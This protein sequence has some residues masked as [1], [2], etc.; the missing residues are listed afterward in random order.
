MNMFKMCLNWKVIGGLAVVG[1]GVAVFA[2][3]LIGAALPLLFLAAC[4]L[5]MLLMMGAMKGGMKDMGSKGGACSTEPEQAEQ[6]VRDTRPQTERIA[7][8][9]GE[10][11][12]LRRRQESLASEIAALERDDLPVVRKAAIVAQAATERGPR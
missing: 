1:L 3:N 2:P 9:T 4:P 8:R 5:S 12:A 6:P 10:L 7:G 11:A